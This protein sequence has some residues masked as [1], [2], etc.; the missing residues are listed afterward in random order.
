ML[1]HALALLMIAVPT[2]APSAQ[3]WSW[4]IAPPRI[5]ARQYHA[6]ATEY[7]AGHRGLDIAAS[8][9]VTVTAPAD[10]TVHFVGVVVDRPVLSIRHPG[11]LISSYEPVSSSLIKG[12]T[13]HRGQPIGV[14]GP[15]H[16]PTGCLHFG[17]RR[18]SAYVSPLNYLGGIPRSVLLPTRRLGPRMRGAV[19]L[20]Q[21]LG[22][23]VGIELSRA[24]AG[25]A[26]HLLHG[27]QV[28]A[29]VEQVSGR[30]MAQGVRPRRSAARKVAQQGGDQRVD[31]A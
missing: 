4:P 28:G 13:V 26:E 30:G 21:P 7:A 2:A 5:I 16:C 8:V 29:A 22:R 31:R 10:G 25:V 27:S 9:G 12:E 17:V 11:G 18:D 3:E 19:G 20:R 6:P 15:G 23:D 24:E 14:V 1:R